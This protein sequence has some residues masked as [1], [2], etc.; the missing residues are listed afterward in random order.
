MRTFHVGGTASRVADK[1]RMEAK[2]NGVVRFINLN[3]RAKARTA[4]WWP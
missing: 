4:R 1:S 2:N 3:T